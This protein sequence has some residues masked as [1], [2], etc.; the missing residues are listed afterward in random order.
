MFERHADD[1]R[2]A[3]IALLPKRHVRSGDLVLQRRQ[4]RSIGHRVR[5]HTRHVQQRGM[6]HRRWR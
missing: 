5:G 1:V 2:R 6:L 4:M 3:R